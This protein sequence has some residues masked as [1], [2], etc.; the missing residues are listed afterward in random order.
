MFLTELT[1][2]VIN[3]EPLIP[4][5]NIATLGE[6]FYFTFVLALFIEMK[7]NCNKIRITTIQNNLI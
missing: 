3:I 1:G 4:I 5:S 7:Q 6:P 2:T